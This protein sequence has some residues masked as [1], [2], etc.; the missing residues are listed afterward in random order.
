MH[1][2]TRKLVF[3]PTIYPTIEIKKLFDIAIL[4]AKRR[5]IQELRRL[6]RIIN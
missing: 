3:K 1:V 5:P 2:L 4:W 6:N